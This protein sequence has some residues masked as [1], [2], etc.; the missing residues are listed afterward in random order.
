MQ[1]NIL[2]YEIEEP[3]SDMRLRIW[4]MSC[5]GENGPG[6]RD[7]TVRQHKGTMGLWTTR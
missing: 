1:A 2:D 4:R 3:E 7:M 6:K 5:E